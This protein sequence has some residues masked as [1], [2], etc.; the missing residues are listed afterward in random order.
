MTLKHNGA[1]LRIWC[2]H[3]WSCP[4]GCGREAKGGI[5]DGESLRCGCDASGALMR[6]LDYLERNGPPSN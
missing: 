6:P 4:S 2:H 3:A 1:I 5:I